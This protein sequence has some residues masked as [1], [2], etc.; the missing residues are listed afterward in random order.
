[1]IA[2]NLPAYTFRIKADGDKSLIYD[3]LRRRFVSLTPEEWVRQHFV[4]YLIEEKGF[5]AGR[6]GNEISLLQNGRKRRCDTV[7]YDLCGEPLAIV[8]YKAPHVEITQAVFDQIVRYN[9]V[10]QVR[11]LIVSN[12]IVHYAVRVDY[13]NHTCHFL[14]GIPTYSDMDNR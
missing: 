6:V 11:Y 13:A 12:G 9:T 2:L 4:R 5:P 8:E 3:E 10:L 14:P 7:V 1:M